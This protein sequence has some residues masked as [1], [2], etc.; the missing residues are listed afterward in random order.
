MVLCFL[1]MAQPAQAATAT[2]GRLGFAGVTAWLQG[3]FASHPAAV[4]PAQKSGSAGP[5]GQVPTSATRAGKGAGN[6]VKPGAGQL[7]PYQRY[8]RKFTA[9]PAGARGRAAAFDPA[10]STFVG[11]KSSATAS[12]YQNADGSVTRRVFQHPMNYQASKG[13]WAPV[14]TTLVAGT[15]GRLQEKANSVQISFAAASA[16]ASASAPSGTSGAGTAAAAAAADLAQVQIGT[17]ESVGWSVAGGAPVTAQVSGSTATYPG[18]L[19]GAKVTETSGPTGVK[20]SIV[21]ASAAAGNV[22]TFPLDARGLTPSLA[23]GGQVVFTDAAGKQAGEIP[24]AF[25]TDSKFNPGTGRG[26]TTWNVSYGLAKQAAGWV[27]TVTVDP[28]WLNDPARVFPVDID[29]TFTDS[30][31]GHS[32]NI[33]SRSADLATFSQ[34]ARRDSG[35]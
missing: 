20:E 23:P 26:A 4:V 18:I 31:V 6:A 7:P 3:L 25:A 29:P 17:G 9:G 35:D 32:A 16:S 10:T 13:V 12:W 24:L 1:A 34:L 27:L 30:I 21:L 5:G 33:L 11:A 28:S 15:G 2:S 8:D 22:F 14:D 19:P